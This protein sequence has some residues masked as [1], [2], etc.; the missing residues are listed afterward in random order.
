MRV[1]RWRS[2]LTW[3]NSGI[4]P[5]RAKAW[6]VSWSQ[7]T[8]AVRRMRVLGFI[9]RSSYAAGELIPTFMGRR[10]RGWR[11]GGWK[12]AKATS[13]SLLFHPLS[14]ILH[15]RLVCLEDGID[16]GISPGFLVE[17]VVADS[18]FV[19]HADFF[20][21]SG[22]GSVGGVAGGHD[23]V[24][25]VLVEPEVEDGAGGFGGV[26]VVPV[27]GVKDVAHV[28]R[29]VI[30]AG[31]GQAD[32]AGGRGGWGGDSSGAGFGGGGGLVGG[33]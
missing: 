12:M 8:P 7:L 25:V 14:S 13:A 30:G 27:I 31:G 28:G 3:R 29:A 18:A 11:I 6:A 24:E 21:D 15:S 19:L 1:G 20:E 9:V 4:A 22:G 23:A 10:K 33:G 5:A 26:A 32:P 17:Q 16:E 2:W